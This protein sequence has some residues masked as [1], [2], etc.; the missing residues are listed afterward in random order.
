MTAKELEHKLLN[1]RSDGINRCEGGVGEVWQSTASSLQDTQ[2]FTAGSTGSLV[3][4]RGLNGVRR[5]PFGVKTEK[6]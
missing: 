2:L 5:W 4:S 3:R 6:L 1:R